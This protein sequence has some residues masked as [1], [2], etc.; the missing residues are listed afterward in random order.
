MWERAGN[1]QT[2]ARR[3]G[4]TDW[5]PPVDVAAGHPED[6]G[7]DASGRSV[8]TLTRSGGILQSAAQAAYRPGPLAPWDPPVTISPSTNAIAGDLAVNAA[9]DAVASVTRWPVRIR[10]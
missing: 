7:V 5:S 6:A 8:V 10:R 4:Q 9:G 3:L 2:V 1:V